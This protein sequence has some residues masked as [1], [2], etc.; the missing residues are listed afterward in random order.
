[1]NNPEENVDRNANNKGHSDEV[2]DG[3]KE[4][5]IGQWRKG[6]PCCN[7]VKNAT[8]LCPCSSI[9]WKVELA[10]DEIGCFIDF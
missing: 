7:M 4:H 8:E 3:S 2:C 9:L 1:M 6:H 5:V 10:S